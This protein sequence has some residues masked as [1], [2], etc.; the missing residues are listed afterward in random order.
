MSESKFL[1]EGHIREYYDIRELHE[2]L[3][4]HEIIHRI[5]KKIRECE[6]YGLDYDAY[7]PKHELTVVLEILECCLDNKDS[8]NIKRR[9]Y[10]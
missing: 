6:K 3:S 9:E 2:V 1:V 4:S 8:P 7:I 10:E 5:L